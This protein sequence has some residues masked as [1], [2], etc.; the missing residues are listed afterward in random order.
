M[1]GPKKF[2]L[3]RILFCL[4]VVVAT[5]GFALGPEDDISVAD[6]SL[7]E[8]LYSRDFYCPNGSVAPSLEGVRYFERP[9]ALATVR[10][11]SAANP[12]IILRISD[13][14]NS[15]IGSDSPFFALYDDGIVIYRQGDEYRSIRLSAQEHQE[16][17]HSVEQ[18]TPSSL[19]GRYQVEAATDA[20]TNNLL[21]YTNDEPVFISVYGSLQNSEILS[22]LPANLGSMLSEIMAFRHPEASTW[23][24]DE[25]EVMLWA[26]EYAPDESIIWPDRWP[27]LDDP[28]TV[29]RGDDS[30]SIFVPAADFDELQVFLASRLPRGAV[31]INGR[32]WA[33]D[34]RFPFPHEELWMGSNRELS[35]AH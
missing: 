29:Q 3:G 11:G 16:I 8:F 28:Q 5:R 21:I 30:Y 35:D 33:A 1:I 34:I 9:R 26:F 23:L 6:P 7:V 4:F 25:I 18:A 31:E 32:K 27:G 20:P 2:A 13:P 24:P 15:V 19:G 22:C 12:E 17:L 14:W 10:A